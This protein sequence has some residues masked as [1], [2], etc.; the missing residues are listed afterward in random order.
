M[1]KLVI[2]L[3][4][5]VVYQTSFAQHIN[6][7]PE[8]IGGQYNYKMI[9]D[10]ELYYPQAAIDANAEG[11]II[12][13]FIVGSNGV[14]KNYEVIQSVHPELDEAYINVLKHLLWNPGKEDGVVKEF[15]TQYSEK[16]KIKKY[17]KLIK[18]RAYN[19]AEYPFHPHG[20]LYQIV[21]SK[22]LEQKAKPYYKD[23]EVNIFKFIQEYIKIPDA[24]VKQGIKGEVEIS[25]IVEV[26]GR[27]SNFKELKGIGGG[28]TEEA[29]RLIQML[30]WEPAK[31]NGA[32]VR[33]EYQIQVNFGNTRY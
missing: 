8:I 11:E 23:K 18:R 7:K 29:Y 2:S 25:F 13:G 32:Y 19:E 6:V 15:K 28:C 10:Q 9:L 16:F 4:F 27:L 33:S 20:D 1:K 24:A 21:S 22:K 17:Q 12:I 31:M 26:S 5:L 30:N 3:F 14:A